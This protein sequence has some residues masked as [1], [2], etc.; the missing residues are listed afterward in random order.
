MLIFQQMDDSIPEAVEA[1]ARERN[2][3]VWPL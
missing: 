3:L 2:P 1:C